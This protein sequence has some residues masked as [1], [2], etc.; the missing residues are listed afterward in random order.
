M[1]II[2]NFWNRLNRIG[3]DSNSFNSEGIETSLIN[4][5]GLLGFI[6]TSLISFAAKVIFPYSNIYIPILF[7]GLCFLGTLLFNYFRFYILAKFYLF[8]LIQSIVCWG[9]CKFG[10]DT[11]VQNISLILFLCP[12]VY[13][14]SHETIQRIIA[15]LIPL[16]GLLALYVSDFRL[17]SNEIQIDSDGFY[18]FQ[19]VVLLATLLA[20]F[21]IIIEFKRSL[22]LQNISI[23]SK[24]KELIESINKVNLLN[25]NLDK[26]VYTVS[27]DLRSPISSALGLIELSKTET[28][29]KVI[30]EYMAIQEKS[31]RRMNEFVSDMLA[32]YK[33]SKSINYYENIDLEKLLDDIIEANAILIKDSKI[34]FELKAEQ[35]DKFRSDPM[36]L[37]IILTNLVSNAI[38]F[39]DDTKDTHNINIQIKTDPKQAVIIVSDNGIGIAEESQEKVFEMF[40]RATFKKS[41]SGLGL[42]M[43]KE[44]LGKLGGTITLESEEK[45]YTK[46]TITIPNQTLS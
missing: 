43:V 40:F 18:I 6:F 28:D 36:K 33:N 26:F 20:Y 13:Y 11:G 38:R 44:L 3:S 17:F 5:A 22:T 45:V 1:G 21:F 14:K 27:H 29:I 19:A 25:E 37:G 30:H 41:G 16:T 23:E 39:I 9:A 34:T 32:Y 2:V 7:F 12:F 15:F 46:F 8:L 24:N 31:M 4:Q 42:F 10:R 35:P